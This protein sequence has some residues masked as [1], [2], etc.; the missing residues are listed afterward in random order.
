VL[1]PCEVHL[2]AFHLFLRMEPLAQ[3]RPRCDAADVEALLASNAIQQDA[4]NPK[5]TGTLEDNE[6]R[7]SQIR[8][9][10]VDETVTYFVPRLGVGREGPPLHP[11]SSF[12]SF[13]GKRTRRV[14][15]FSPESRRRKRV[16]HPEYHPAQDELLIKKTK[17]NTAIVSFRYRRGPGK[18]TSKKVVPESNP[19]EFH[20][21]G[22]EGPISLRGLGEGTAHKP[23]VSYGKVQDLV[24][25]L[26]R[27]L[28][29]VVN[30]SARPESIVVR[31]GSARRAWIAAVYLAPIEAEGVRTVAIVFDGARIDGC[32]A[33]SACIS[34]SVRGGPGATGM[35]PADSVRRSCS[36]F[37]GMHREDCDHLRTVGGSSSGLIQRVL[38][39]K[40]KRYL[41]E[42]VS[43][44]V[45]LNNG[46]RR[47][48]R[49][50]ISYNRKE[51]SAFRPCVVLLVE[52]KRR[53]L[54]TLSV[55]M[56]IECTSCRRHHSNRGHCDHE[57]AVI[58]S[59]R[60]RRR[61][62]GT[63]FLVARIKKRFLISHA[64]FHY[65]VIESSGKE[66]GS[67][68]WTK[69]ASA[70][71]ASERFCIALTILINMRIF[72]K[73]ASDGSSFIQ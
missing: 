1:E 17:N 44:A 20:D 9:F 40:N 21:V 53:G 30:G 15:M 11:V 49:F 19:H 24:E 54:K 57:L 18:A 29:C 23:I 46:S 50:W 71:N 63:L 70:F 65:A 43:G 41:K 34:F 6:K 28:E 33:E 38:S 59:V 45:E 37:G 35:V 55:S 42:D 26:L 4:Q 60:S 27:E 32:L 48:Y 7:I 56:R 16:N 64:K 66:T 25:K 14:L 8:R 52:K 36:C 67:K 3:G 31:V 39:I 62:N 51:A 47:W 2:I 73:V 72:V 61:E 68:R 58:T 12:R 69:T 22:N 13:K 5:T 10:P